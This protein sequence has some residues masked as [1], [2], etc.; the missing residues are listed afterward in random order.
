MLN[1]REYIINQAKEIERLKEIIEEKDIKIAALITRLSR[2]EGKLN[3]IENYYKIT[4][5]R[6]FK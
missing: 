2:A 4:E 5:G 1:N 3:K 6:E